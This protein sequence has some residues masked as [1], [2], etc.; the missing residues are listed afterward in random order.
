MNG[1]SFVPLLLH[2]PGNKL[3]RVLSLIND[4]GSIGITDL[5]DKN[6]FD[7]SINDC[8]KDNDFALKSASKPSNTHSF[9]AKDVNIQY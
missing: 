4:T 1:I 7:I 9:V 8:V 5:E 3:S 2:L 6:L